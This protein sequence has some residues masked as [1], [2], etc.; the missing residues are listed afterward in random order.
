MTLAELMGFL[1]AIAGAIIFSIIGH[2]YFGW[3]GTILGGVGGLIAGGIAGFGFIELDSRIS[4]AMER[5]S[6]RWL[7][8]K[9]FWRYWADT[10]AETW[11]YVKGGVEIGESVTGKVVARRYYGVFLD[12]GRGFPALL[13]KLNSDE[14]T[15]SREPA[16]GEKIEAQVKEID[17]QKRFFV[18]TQRTDE[19]KQKKD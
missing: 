10:E 18:L 7:L 9:H 3:A 8:K 5:R 1:G 4:V 19:K 11:D 15:R 2:A 14:A 16:T 6:Q 17:D 13:T 12:I